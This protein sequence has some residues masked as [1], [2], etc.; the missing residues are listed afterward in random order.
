MAQNSPDP[1]KARAEAAEPIIPPG[2]LLVLAALAFIVGLIAS[3]TQPEPGAIGIGGLA[4]GALMLLLWVI[5]APSQAAALLT[6]RA[7][8]FGGTSVIVTVLLLAALVF[9]YVVVRNLDL[10]ADLTERSEFSLTDESR[11]AIAALGS[12]SS[13]PAVEITA[14][15][16]AA[17]AGRRD[18]DDPLLQDYATTSTGKITYR[19]I[20]PDLEP[21]LVQRYGVTSTGQVVVAATDPATGE[22]DLENA[23]RLSFL[24]QQ[25]L[26]NAVLKVSAQGN[27]R[28]L[29]ITTVD[30]D[31]ATMTVLRDI[32]TN[33]L[34]WD[35]QDISLA[36][37]SSPQSTITLND[38]NIDGDIMII[39][40]GS[41][42]LSEVELGV[43]QAYL[44][45]GGNLLI[46]AD[47]NLNDD[48]V[49]LATAANLSAYLEATFGLRFNN[50][51]IVDQTQALQNP[52]TPVAIDYDPAAYISTTGIDAAQ[53]ITVF[54]LASSIAL[55]ETAPANV[56]TAALVR[57]GAT[58]Y[59][60]ADLT[61]VLNGELARAETDA[62][63]P[64][65]V[66]AQAEN[67]QT[68]ARVIL[69]S[70][71]ALAND[72]L[73]VGNVANLS[74]ALNSIVWATNYEDFFQTIN[75][76]QASR[77]QDQPIV[78]TEGQLATINTFVIGLPFA[79]LLIGGALWLLNR[80]QR[81]AA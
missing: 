26:T 73:A 41:Q 66:M 27:F 76:L 14:F 59:A 20:D 3:F 55:A 42:P 39:P 77:P 17:Q 45:G 34:D 6:G 24:N 18:Q 78:A 15:Y 19:F 54:D 22:L 23:E 44:A 16:G 38:P 48:Q 52:L 64:L 2:S 65:V 32:L 58:S 7:A 43:I 47:T 79:V 29:F 57:T 46:M 75:V 8:R 28:A 56:I 81:S 67:S 33:Q 61:A 10:R 74:L 69:A 60:K 5:L 62:A 51:V 50:D 35:V 40:G 9:V 4:F 31:G 68:G 70:S 80:E 25:E 71:T 30:G 12:D 13:L 72:Q 49:S 63:G 53:S 21:G 37:L 11:A 36:Q 1:I